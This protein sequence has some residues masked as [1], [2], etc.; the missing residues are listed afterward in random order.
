MSDIYSVLANSYATA[1]LTTQNVKYT[2][3][4]AKSYEG[5]WS[6]TYSNG[7]KFEFQISQV[8]GFRA[9]VKYQSDG[10]TQYQQVLIGNSSFRIGDTKFVLTGSGKALVGNVITDPV[11]GS[12]SLVKGNATQAT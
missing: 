9:R 5:T 4:N 7:Q 11:T 2:P 8:S 3:V 10:S 12:T 6:G 1:Q